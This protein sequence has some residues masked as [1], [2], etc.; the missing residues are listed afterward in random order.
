MQRISELC[1]FAVS[2][3]LMLGKSVISDA[4]KLRNEERVDD[5]SKVDWPEDSVSKAKIIRSKA[6]VMCRDVESVANSF[7]TGA[8]PNL[9]LLVHPCKCLHVLLN[10]IREYE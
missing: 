2:H 4:N 5:I 10:S 1:S 3:L 9:I 8:R 7:V 6:Q